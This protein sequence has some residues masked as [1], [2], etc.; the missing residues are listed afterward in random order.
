MSYITYIRHRASRHSACNE[1]SLQCIK[2]TSNSNL[3][4]AQTSIA[5]SNRNSQRGSRVQYSPPNAHL[6][7]LG[8][9][10]AH[11]IHYLG[12]NMS[13]NAPKNPIFEATL[14]KISSKMPQASLP[15]TP[16]LQKTC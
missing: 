16:K 4:R 15:T 12:A 1:V 5:R 8:C 11:L 7:P 13:E 10:L 3:L 2:S 14:P 9:H 6:A